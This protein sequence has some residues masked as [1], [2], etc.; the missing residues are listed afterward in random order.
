MNRTPV[1]ATQD[2]RARGE[3]G[4]GLQAVPCAP[5]G[6]VKDTRPPAIQDARPE[7]PRDLPM[8]KDATMV[9]STRGLML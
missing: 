7:K 3:G 6:I 4:G 2:T 1:S 8:P 5:M 9:N